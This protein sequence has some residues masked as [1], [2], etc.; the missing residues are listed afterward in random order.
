MA[1]QTSTT[2]ADVTREVFTASR[3]EKQFYDKEDWLSRIERTDRWTVGKKAVVPIHKGRGGGE[4]TWAT[5]TETALNAA[6]YQKVDRAEY[7]VP[8]HGRQ[9]SIDVSAYNEA[10]GGDTA[11]IEA[12]VLEVQGVVDDLKHGIEREFV[13]NGDALIAKCTTSSGTAVI[14][15]ATDGYGYDALL[16]GWLYPGQTVDIGT[17]G[18]EVAIADA[19]LITDVAISSSAPSITISSAVTT[20]TSHY[21]SIANARAATT[22]YEANGLRTIAGSASTAI[23]GLDPDT[24]GESFWKPASIGTET[25]LSLN[26]ILNL[27]R[28][29]QMQ[30]KGANFLLTSLKQRQAL[31]EL[32]QNQVRFGTDKVSAGGVESVT[33]N[34]L[35]IMAAVAIPDREMYLLNLADLAIV[36]GAKITAPK[37]ASDIQGTSRGLQWRQGYSS[38][39]DGVFYPCQLAAK[40]RNGFAANISLTD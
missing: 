18:D 31:Y 40:R 23:G 20:S 34:G 14:S 2:L 9:I 24:A 3:L 11:A 30:S 26:G 16:R 17:T 25:T 12:V 38:F 27:Q 7:T 5:G 32:L 21:V 19:S 6:S 4:T 33:W 35:E 36:T 8:Y 15:L 10:N 22:S 28:A 39:V 13:S 1:P 29:T 37:F